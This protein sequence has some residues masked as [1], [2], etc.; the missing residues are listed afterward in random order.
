MTNFRNQYHA[1]TDTNMF[2]ES[3]FNKLKTYYMKRKPTR[4]IDDLVDILLKMEKD[5]YISQ[6]RVHLKK[7]SGNIPH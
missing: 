7:S 5:A 2:C 1:G 6:V 3:S 4:R